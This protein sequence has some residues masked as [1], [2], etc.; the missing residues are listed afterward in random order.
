MVAIFCIN[1]EMM[2]SS[3][4]CFESRLKVGLFLQLDYDF[5]Y[6]K[7][8]VYANQVIKRSI[9]QLNLKLKNYSFLEVRLTDW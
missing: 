2:N 5:E 8:N 6:C 1:P 4:F 3:P 9:S 7:S